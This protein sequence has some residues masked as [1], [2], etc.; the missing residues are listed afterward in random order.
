MRVT[1]ILL[2]LVGSLVSNAQYAPES[3]VSLGSGGAGIAG[4]FF[5]NGMNNPAALAWTEE[6]S[7]GVGY[8]TRFML[9]ELSDRYF[10]VAYPRKDNG[11]TFSINVNQYGFSSYSLTKGGL[12]YSRFF[13]PNFVAALQF[14]VFQFNLGDETYGSHTAFTF[15]GGSE[16]KLNDKIR[17]GTQIFNPAEVELSAYGNEKI[18]PSIAAGCALTLTEDAVFM[19]DIVKEMYRPAALR[20]GF[21][22]LVM[23]TLAIR[24]GVQTAPF[25]IS[26]GA[27]LHLKN[28]EVDFATSYHQILGVSPSISLMF[29]LNKQ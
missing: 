22:Y 6:I 9:S 13:G 15:E 5:W 18:P 24:G 11:G 7:A 1:L 20:T 16:Y 26:G 8:N 3:A 19:V 2:L 28:F 25:S 27:G 21:S 10:M 12:A 23:N 29:H 14:D 4:D 17:L